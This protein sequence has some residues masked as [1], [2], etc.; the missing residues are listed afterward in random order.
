MPTSLTSQ[1]V[2]EL[3]RRYLA[4]TYKRAPFVL[5]RGRG[6][7]VWDMEGRRYLDFIAGISVNPLGHCPPA[8][9]EVLLEQGARL[10]HVSNLYHSAP[11]AL[12]ARDLCDSSFADRVFFCNSGTEASEGAIKFARKANGRP[13]FIS[14]TGAFHGRSVG[15]LSLTASEKYRMPFEPLMPGVRFCPYNDL[16]AVSYTHLTLPT[17][18][19][20]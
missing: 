1:A 19:L 4:P 6:V 5:E 18:D 17:S 7:E 9:Q 15:A 11:H 20:V 16:E 14:F 10:M 13:Q 8:V 2:I 3:E 12:L